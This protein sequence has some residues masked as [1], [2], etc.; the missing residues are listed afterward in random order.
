M[1][2]Q[3]IDIHVLVNNQWT[4]SFKENRPRCYAKSLSAQDAFQS[5]PGFSS[6]AGVTE[7]WGLLSHAQNAVR[8]LA[9]SKKVDRSSS[10]RLSL[11]AAVHQR[12]SL[13]QHEYNLFSVVPWYTLVHLS[14]SFITYQQVWKSGASWQISLIVFMIPPVHWTV[15]LLSK[16]CIMDILSEKGHQILLNCWGRVI[17]LQCFSCQLMKTI[18]FNS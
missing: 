18:A 14:L 10:K 11:C 8:W 3:R 1:Q 15:M 17:N 16:L 12:W 2:G 5:I 13:E 9:L 7:R 4:T 6:C